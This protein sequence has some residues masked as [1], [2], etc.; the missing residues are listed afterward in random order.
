MTFRTVFIT[1]V[2]TGVGKTVTACGLI[3]AARRAGQRISAFKPVSSGFDRDDPAGSDAGRL[4]AALGLPLTSQNLDIAAPLRFAAPLSPPDA[5]ALEDAFL[6]MADLEERCT[7]RMAQAQLADTLLLIEGAGGVMSPI[8]ASGLNI[9]LIEKFRLPVVLSAAN[10]L[11]VISQVLTALES[12]AERRLPLLAV[13]LHDLT[14]GGPP[15]ADTV[16]TLR[17]YAPGTVILAGDGWENELL[18]TV[19]GGG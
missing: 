14:P 19:I 10:Q 12:L 2:G 17:Y 1:G 16:R 13:V 11:G 18:T 15:V 4:L 5:A 6:L 8:A 3:L 7:H 9:T